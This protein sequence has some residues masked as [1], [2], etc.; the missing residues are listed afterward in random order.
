MWEHGEAMEEISV[1]E[2]R[3]EDIEQAANLVVRMKRL[4]NEFDPLF[5]VVDDASER[6]NNY[7]SKSLESR[8][9]LVLVAVKGKNVVGVLR[10]EVK[11]RT[12]YKP[13]M[14][15]NITDF[16]ILPEHRRRALGNT[17]LERASKALGKLGAEVVTAEFPARNEIA[18]KFYSKRRFRALT[19]IYA[20]STEQAAE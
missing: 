1:R 17:M 2:A 19:N 6:A 15:G 9:A 8:S 20:E 18:V 3:R 12:F 16:Y 5:T 14:G 4:N 7:L 11:E 13:T 10:A